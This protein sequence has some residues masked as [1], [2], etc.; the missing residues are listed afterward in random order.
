MPRKERHVA[1]ALWGEGK[2]ID[3]LFSLR[4]QWAPAPSNPVAYRRE[5]VSK[6]K[7]EY[8]VISREFSGI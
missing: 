3:S 5:S 1:S 4:L 6:L 8:S 2:R 7:R